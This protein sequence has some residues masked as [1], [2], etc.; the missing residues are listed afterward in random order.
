MHA[1]AATLKYYCSIY[2]LHIKLDWYTYFNFFLEYLYFL[3]DFSD[4]VY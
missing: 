2:K 4:M 1:I 3:V